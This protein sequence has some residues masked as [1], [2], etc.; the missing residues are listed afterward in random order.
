MVITNVKLLQ[1]QSKS[2]DAK[3]RI[4]ISTNTRGTNPNQG[5]FRKSRSY[6][7]QIN[8]HYALYSKIEQM[9]SYLLNCLWRKG[10]KMA[11]ILFK[12]TPVHEE[13]RPYHSI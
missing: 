13:L 11:L 1:S 9:I 8:L 10:V 3:G 6:T 2:N 4:Y 5:K 12:I 7:F